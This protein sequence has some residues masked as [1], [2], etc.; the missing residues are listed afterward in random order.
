MALL[1]QS[2][3]LAPQLVKVLPQAAQL[4]LVVQQL[5][6]LPTD[7]I[8][9]ALQPAGRISTP[10]TRRE[11]LIY[12]GWHESVHALLCFLWNALTTASCSAN[13]QRY[14]C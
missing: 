12:T 13:L 2:C 1:R 4:V 9:T 6:I 3:V 14:Q 11:V 8:I 5:V 7:D 10:G